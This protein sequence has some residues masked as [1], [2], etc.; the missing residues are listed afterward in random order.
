MQKLLFVPLG[1]A[2]GAGVSAGC[3]AP[4][5]YSSE[6]SGNRVNRTDNASSNVAKVA[7]TPKMPSHVATKAPVESA[8]K[9]PVKVAPVKMAV[10]TAPAK[11]TYRIEE[12]DPRM[13]P[14]MV[15]ALKKVAVS[16]PPASFRL[17]KNPRVK[18]ATNQGTITVALDAKAA[19]LHVKSFYYLAKRGFFDN[20]VFHRFA[21]LTGQGGNIIQGGDPLTRD[22]KNKEF[23]GGGGPGYSIPRERNNLKH[24][25]LVVAAART[26]DPDSAGSGFYI[27]QNP[28]GFLD[29]GDGYTVF[30]KVVEGQSVALKLRQD[31]TI[32]KITALP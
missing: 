28:V 14:E 5:D 15:A 24:D 18:I 31:D 8:A 6:V 12:T 17:P 10:K 26:P 23:W 16:P 9:A 2:I 1:L 22:V 29:E 7:A 20:T 19:P 4:S 3:V 13:P 27:T 11:A 21:D 30:G 25:K 32:R